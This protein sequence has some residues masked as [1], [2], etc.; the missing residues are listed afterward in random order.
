MTPIF[1]SFAVCAGVI[2]N[3]ATHVKG[4]SCSGTAEQG[5]LGG[6]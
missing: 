1:C 3:D 4:H 6:L 5:R 2:I